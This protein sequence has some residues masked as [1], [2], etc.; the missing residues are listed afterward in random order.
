MHRAIFGKTAMSNIIFCHLPGFAL[1]S[2]IRA[3]KKRCS[4][5]IFAQDLKEAVIHPTL[6]Q[7]NQWTPATEALLLGTALVMSNLGDRL[8][9]DHQERRFGLY[10]LDK[11]SHRAVW[12]KH[13]AFDSDLASLIRGFASQRA[14][15]VNPEQELV[16]NLSY[17]TAMAWATYHYKLSHSGLDE[18]PDDPCNLHAL[19]ICW[20]E[21]YP[22]N[23]L[24]NLTKD[25]AIAT[26]I[27]GMHNIIQAPRGKPQL[28]A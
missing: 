28:V 7:L 16:T 14:F 25:E 3:G 24:S 15:L 2:I 10:L 22:H 9:S 18:F 27:A 4:M 17:A 19:A 20:F 21:N 8:Y 26:F 12:D 13:L 5:G 1:T 11:T 23:G 6:T